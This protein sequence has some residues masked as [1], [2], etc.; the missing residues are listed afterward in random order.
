MSSG[1]DFLTFKC[2]NICDAVF[3]AQMLHKVPYVPDSNVP[4]C[5][6]FIFRQCNYRMFLYIIKPEVG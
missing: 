2:M 4:N 3:T 5:I 6:Y 1:S